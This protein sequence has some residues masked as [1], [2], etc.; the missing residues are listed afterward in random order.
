MS[1]E[2]R[3]LMGSLAAC[4][5]PPDLPPLHDVPL[6]GR[7]FVPCA[8]AAE[9]V[10]VGCAIDGD[11]LDVGGCG[12]ARTD[13]IRLL[14]VD[15]PEV[16]TEDQPAECYAN[17]TYDFVAD[18]IDGEHVSLSYDRACTGAF[19]RSL[20][21]VWLRGDQLEEV[22][23]RSAFEP[24]LWTWPLDPDEPAILLNEVLLGLGWARDYPE[25]IAGTL[26]FQDRLDRARDGARVAGRGLWG[27]CLD[28]DG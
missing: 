15:A 8:S 1:S 26:L 7:P 5:A 24:Y 16:E 19:G 4:Y 22:R 28:R 2:L 14:G 12:E 20:A 3:L 27:A 13:R 6:D 18:L 17:A 11:T 10:R 25:E 9:H 23:D 21:Y